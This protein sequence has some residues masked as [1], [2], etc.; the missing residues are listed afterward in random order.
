MIVAPGS[1][2]WQMQ[3]MKVALLFVLSLALIVAASLTWTLILLRP[4]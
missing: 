3:I 4:A 1:N 2:Q